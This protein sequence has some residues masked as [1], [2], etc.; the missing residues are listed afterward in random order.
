M[1]K[2]NYSSNTIEQFAINILSLSYDCMYS[3]FIWNKKNDNFDYT[4]KDSKIALEVSLVIPENIER[5]LAYQNSNKPDISTIQLHKLD[6]ND[7][8]IRYYGGSICE[9]KKKIIDTIKKKNLKALRR[10]NNNIEKYQLCLCIHDGG[11]FEYPDEWDFLK[12]NIDIQVSIFNQIFLIT[13]CKLFIFDKSNIIEIPIPT[14]NS[15]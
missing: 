1:I 9:L 4:S 14:K 15:I 7:N 13:D 11:L 8:L 5:V 3:D 6:Q 12:S 10:Q 2:L